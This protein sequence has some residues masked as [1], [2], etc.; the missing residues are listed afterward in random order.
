MIAFSQRTKELKIGEKTR[1]KYF[2]KFIWFCN[3]ATKSFSV[4]RTLWDCVKSVRIRSYSGP[5]FPAFGL[6][7]VLNNSEYGHL[8]N[9]VW[10]N[11]M[12]F[13]ENSEKWESIL[14]NIYIYIY[15]IYLEICIYMYIWKNVYIYILCIYIYYILY[16][17]YII[18]HIIYT[19]IL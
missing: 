16:K 19:Y 8:F 15:N 1:H 10:I 5:Y 13:Q 7:T 12:R 3:C 18:I 2:Q 14:S 4:G 11:H 17:L 9:A 6:N